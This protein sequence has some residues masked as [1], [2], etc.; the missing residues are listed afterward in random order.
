VLEVA[1]RFADNVD[2]NTKL[3]KMY[4]WSIPPILTCPG[5]T[6]LCGGEDGVC[7]AKRLYTRPTVQT[8]WDRSYLISKRRDFRQIFT[9]AL[10]LLPTGILRLHVSGDFYNERYSLD[11]L[12]ALHPN[13]HIYPF[14]FTR[15]WRVPEIRAA[16]ESMGG[17]PKWLLASTDSETGPAPA[18]MRE[19]SMLDIWLPDITKGS[20]KAPRGLCDEQRD[21]EVT[22]ATCG[23]C[24]LVRLENRRGKLIPVPLPKSA[25]KIGVG[26]ARHWKKCGLAA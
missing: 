21:K 10:A 14:G 16:L 19:A 12:Q 8:A 22:C 26:F 7:Y 9:E 11:M 20:V 3:G 23:R 24:P 2:E 15:S 25:E 1:S 18:G 13:A 6:H 17:W 4:S 5:R